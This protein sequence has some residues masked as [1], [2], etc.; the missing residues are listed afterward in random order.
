MARVFNRYF[1]D[2]QTGDCW[3]SR[4]RTITETDLVSFAAWSGDWYPLHTDQEWARNTSYGQ[5]IAH[6]MLVLS[7]AIG[8]THLE[9][10]TVAAFYGLDRVRFVAPT[11]IGDTIHVTYEFVEKQER[12]NDG[13]VTAKLEVKKQT[14][15]TVAAAVVK[16]LVNKCPVSQ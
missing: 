14:G 12:E 2:F 5:R 1:E 6:G 3:S 11:F 10:G 16:F 4:G 9:P 13:I 8:L 7:A 15:Q